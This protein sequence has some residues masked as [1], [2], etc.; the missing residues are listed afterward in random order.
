[1]SKSPIYNTTQ[2]VTEVGGIVYDGG[3]ARSPGGFEV[4]ADNQLNAFGLA[5]TGILMK[6]AVTYPMAI[7]HVDVFGVDTLSFNT[8]STAA[9]FRFDMGGDVIGMAAGFISLPLEPTADSHAVTKKYVDDNSGKWDDVTGGISYTDGDVSTTGNIQGVNIYGGIAGTIATGVG[10]GCVGMTIND[11]HGN[12]NLVFNHIAGVADYA[13]NVGRIVVNTD[14]TQNAKMTFEVAD[15]AVAGSAA[16]GNPKLTIASSGNVTAEGGFTVNTDNQINSFGVSGTG[17]VLKAAVSN[18]MAIGQVN[19]ASTDSL[20]FN[21]S[22]GT[23][24]YRFWTGSS[25]VISMSAGF[26]SLPLTPT[27]TSHAVRKDYVDSKLTYYLPQVVGRISS[28]GALNSARGISSV[29]KVGTGIYDVNLSPSIPSADQIIQI[30]TE[31]GTLCGGGVSL[32]S[33]QIRVTIINVLTNAYQDSRFYITVN[34][35]P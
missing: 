34:N 20:D 15:N 9:A 28:G 21:T 1:M 3:V 13:G 30:T 35:G 26:M 10:S 32:S 29:S 4:N 12:A 11:G 2:W 27:A 33:T 23:Q 31:Y 8:N 5:A 18:T 19:L 17:L 16:S 25:N 24:S 6:A 14:S 22:N 7:G